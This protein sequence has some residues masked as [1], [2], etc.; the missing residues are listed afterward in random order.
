MR[1]TSRGR[2]PKRAQESSKLLLL[3]PPTSETSVL[4]ILGCLQ[5][6]ATIL[7]YPKSTQQPLLRTPY[8]V[9]RRIAEDIFDLE[10]CS[11]NLSADV[12]WSTSAPREKSLEERARSAGVDPP[13]TGLTRPSGMNSKGEL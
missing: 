1:P 7:L 13:P 6:S 3:S 2:L 12:P 10:S 5:S 8:A 11:M 9:H 4:G